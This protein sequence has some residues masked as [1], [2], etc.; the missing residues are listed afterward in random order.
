MVGNGIEL[1]I[2]GTVAIELHTDILGDLLISLC[3]SIAVNCDLG[4]VCSKSGTQL[5]WNGIVDVRNFVVLHESPGFGAWVISA[6]YG[7]I[8]TII[9]ITNLAFL[10]SSSV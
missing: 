7:K 9:D 5:G 3:S 6:L 2:L 1:W 4:V 10:F 8:L